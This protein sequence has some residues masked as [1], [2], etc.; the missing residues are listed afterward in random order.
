MIKIFCDFCKEEAPMDGNF[1][2]EAQ[3]HELK[4]AIDSRTMNTSKQV[5]KSMIQLCQSCYDKKI[6]PLLKK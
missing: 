6:V 3:V 5:V 2:F 4:E 1:M